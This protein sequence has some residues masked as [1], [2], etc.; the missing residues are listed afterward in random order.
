MTKKPDLVVFDKETQQYDAAIK[1]YGTSASSPVIKPLNTAT[2]RNDGVDRVNKQFK[3][4]FDE[5]KKE[6]EAMME[7]F[8]YNDLVYNAKFNFE[9]IIGEVY[10]LYNDKNE[11]SFLSIIQPDQCNFKYLGSFRLNSQKMWEKL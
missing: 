6:Y 1:P 3:S 5:L 9:P 4:K 11:E 10:Y 7:Q 8:E 2:W